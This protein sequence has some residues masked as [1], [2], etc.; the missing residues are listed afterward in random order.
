[1]ELGM[2]MEHWLDIRL[3]VLSMIAVLPGLGL[4]LWVRPP[5]GLV[6]LLLTTILDLNDKIRSIMKSNAS[7]ENLWV[8]WERCSKYM[9]LQPENGYRDLKLLEQRFKKGQPLL[10]ESDVSKT[11][12]HLQRSTTQWPTSGLL[13]FKNFSVK[14]RPGLPYVIKNLDFRIEYG[15]KIGIVGSTGA[16]K[17]TLMSAI[18]K[19]FENYKG[20][21]RLDN[22]EIS[23]PDL[24]TLRRNITIIPQDPHLFNDTLRAN[25]D[26]LCQFSDEKII[27]IFKG[28]D[29]WSKFESRDGLAYKI[30]SEGGNL[31][32]GEKQL[33]C[34]VR[35]LLKKSKLILLDEATANIDTK[36]EVLIENAI[37]NKFKK[38]T[39]LMIAHRL[40]TVMGCDKILVLEN[41]EKLEFDKL[42]K[43]RDNKESIFGRMV[44][45]NRDIRKYME[46]FFSVFYELFFGSYS[47]ILI[48][49]L[50]LTFDLSEKRIKIP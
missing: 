8:S 25:V 36:T 23:K 37:K 41:G 1:M 20:E 3:T 24:K 4:M 16:G 21:I 44:A 2:A 34:L 32:Q 39:V 43:L 33:L 28:F 29:I 5:I 17:T 45:I 35:A 47:T 13:K 46:Y 30:Q 11:A 18:Y 15:E 12:N 49:P 38:S 10:E 14:Y 50:W 26:P 27:N 40:N 9:Y 22:D 31:S 7:F 42:E 19:N 48:S 6:A